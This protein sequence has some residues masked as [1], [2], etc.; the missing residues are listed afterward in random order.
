MLSDYYRK[1]KYA[2]KHDFERLC[3]LPLT[4][5]YELSFAGN[6]IINHY[7]FPQRIKTRYKGHP[8]MLTSWKDD[9]MRRKFVQ[10]GRRMTSR[11]ESLMTHFY[12]GYRFNQVSIASMKPSFARYVYN[13]LLPSGRPKDILDP[14]AGWGARLLGALSLGHNYRGYDTN[15][16]MRS[17]YRLISCFNPFDAR[18]QVTI[19]DSARV[20][21]P[22]CEYDLVFTS[23]P[24]FIENYPHMPKYDS[25]EHFW[26][27]LMV[28]SMKH[29]YA[30]LR[31]DRW[32]CI[33]VNRDMFPQLKSIMGRPPDKK[34]TVPL[35]TWKNRPYKEYVYCWHKR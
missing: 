22:E 20:T 29:S 11:Q 23:P 10:K 27:H 26:S 3:A 32:F 19:A 15:K 4:R 28:P 14:F 8:S 30:A 21:M 33:N 31:H 12:T 9:L 17:A 5:T 7:S 25:V 35:A 13:L 34:I 18:A 1:S 24:Y 16:G 2:L 6:K